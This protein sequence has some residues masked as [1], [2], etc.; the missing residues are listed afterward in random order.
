M[1]NRISLFTFRVRIIPPLPHLEDQLTETP[2]LGHLLH[3][4]LRGMI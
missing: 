3:L 2:R 1:V 4:S